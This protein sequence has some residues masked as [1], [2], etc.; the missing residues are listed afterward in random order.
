MRSSVRCDVA[1]T[2]SDAEIGTSFSLRQSHSVRTRVE[3]KRGKSYFEGTQAVP[4]FEPDASEKCS[5]YPD[6]S[7]SATMSESQ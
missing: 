5:M 7:C 1:A 6:C 3:G 2:F 4:R